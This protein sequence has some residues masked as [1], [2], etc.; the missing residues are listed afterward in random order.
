MTLRLH[1]GGLESFTASSGKITLTG[2]VLSHSGNAKH[3]NMTEDGKERESGTEIKV[4]DAAGKAIKGLPDKGGYFEI[5]LP[6][7]LLENQSK[8]L[9]LGWIDFYRG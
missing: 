8:S 7:A 5:R 1:I 2:S 4:L 6:K 9:E 3:L